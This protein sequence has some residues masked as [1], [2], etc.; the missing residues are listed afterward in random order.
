MKELNSDQIRFLKEHNIH[1]KYVF[2][3]EGL[4]KSEY[5]IIMKELNKLIAYNVSPCQKGE[6]T[7]RTR[8]GH[9]CQ[10][11]TSTIAYQKR[12]DSAG[13]VYIAG[14]LNGQLIKIG[15][16]KALEVREESLNRTKYAG[17]ND[18]KI[19]Y[20]LKS[21]KAGQIE[22]KS[23]SLLHQYNFSTD[24]K[25]DGNWHDSSETY[26]CAYSKAKEFVEKAYTHII[27][28]VLIERNSLTKE[29]EFRNIKR[30]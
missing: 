18:W 1:P 11:N 6:H 10:C 23:N 14:T 3:A 8:S 24:Y 9:C 25:H 22:T 15:F 4:S 16:S 5:R 13:I 17:F 20:A 29:Y 7:L 27:G 26:K 2:N 12:N 21:E 28:N 19:L 30:Q